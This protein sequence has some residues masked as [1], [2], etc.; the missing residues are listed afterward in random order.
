MEV[1]FQLSS[2]PDSTII[3]INHRIL[4]TICTHLHTNNSGWHCKQRDIKQHIFCYRVRGTPPSD[5]TTLTRRLEV[6]ERFWDLHPLLANLFP[7]LFPGG[8]EAFIVIIINHKYLHHE[9]IFLCASL[10]E[11][12][13]S[14]NP[15]PSVQRSWRT[16]SWSAA[17]IKNHLWD[18]GHFNRC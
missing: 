2:S 1:L 6:L 12:W 15:C 8:G 7:T 11:C 10:N 9:W 16:T 17:A 18:P 5:V 14:E 3:N 13:S 4:F